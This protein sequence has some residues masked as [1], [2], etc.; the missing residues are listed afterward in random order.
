LIFWGWAEPV[1]GETEWNVHFFTGYNSASL[2][3]LN[4]EKLNETSVI[5]P[6]LGGSPSI[7]GGP[8]V[9]V[10]VEWRVRPR[11]SLVAFVSSWEGE[12]RALESGEAPFQDN[13]II[14]FSADRITRLTFNE[15]ALRGRYHLLDSPK[16]HRLYLEIGFFDQVQVTY[17]EDY[18]YLF[19]AT[20]GDTL[21]NISS[22]AVGKGGY[23]F[24]WGL[25]GDIYLNKWAAFSLNANYRQGKAVPIYYKSFRHTFTEQDAIAGAD[26]RGSPFPVT[27]E[28]VLLDGN[29]DRPL[30]LELDGWQ[31]SAGIRIFF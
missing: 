23:L 11:F 16:R 3:T 31:A 28:K 10:E 21:R 30:M 18:S 8:L 7:Q 12:S 27:G 19:Q 29:R 5:P 2:K 9:G 13:G 4:D 6:V 14:P 1:W 24:E 20:A 17:R 25:G 15:Y 26:G 22:R